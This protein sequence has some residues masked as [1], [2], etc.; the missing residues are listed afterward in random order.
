MRPL[1]PHSILLRSTTYFWF[2]RI[3]FTLNV[4][5]IKTTGI[6]KDNNPVRV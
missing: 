6:V 5:T 4:I 1:P 2:L 3:V